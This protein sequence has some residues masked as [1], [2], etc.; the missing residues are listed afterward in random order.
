M[1]YLKIGILGATGQIGTEI[2]KL[3][4]QKNQVSICAFA[5]NTEKAKMLLGNNIEVRQFNFLI[6]DNLVFQ[7]IDRIFWLIPNEDYPENEWMNILKSSPIKKIVLLSSIYPDIFALRDSELS[8]EKTRIPY[9]ILRPNTFMQNFNNFD[10][11]SIIK[12]NAFYYPA[13]TA[14]TSFIDIRDIAESAV[15]TLLNGENENKIYTLTG[16]ESLNYYQAAE[17]ISN[18]YG[19]TIRY[20]DT[21]AHPEFEKDDNKHDIIWQNFFSGVRKNLF[22]ETTLDLSIL[23]GHSARTFTHYANDYW[24][25][26]R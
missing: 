2:I 15:N 22:S 13:S 20:I 10:K 16:E 14:R 21:Y 9:T 24:K 8:I 4:L 12:N 26:I 17:I 6:P 19:K 7:N 11:E 5:R 1:T 23:L 25:N 3:L 18:S